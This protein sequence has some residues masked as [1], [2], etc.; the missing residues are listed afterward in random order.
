MWLTQFYKLTLVINVP[1]FYYPEY[2]AS[3]ALSV[4]H[5][6]YHFTVNARNLASDRSEVL[7]SDASTVVKWIRMNNF[8][9]PCIYL[10]KQKLCCLHYNVLLHLPGLET[11]PTPPLLSNLRTP[12]A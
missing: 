6:L 8:L 11:Y 3:S 12:L 2:R 9:V 7:V 5:G 10:E 4:P 1:N